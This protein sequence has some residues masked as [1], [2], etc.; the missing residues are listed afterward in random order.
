MTNNYQ[1]LESIH[2]F[3][4]ICSEEFKKWL[5]KIRNV[6]FEDLCAEIIHIENSQVIRLYQQNMYESFDI[7]LLTVKNEN[8]NLYKNKD[9]VFILEIC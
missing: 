2:V 3:T 8:I 9:N 1:I 7:C 6:S 4:V 5:L